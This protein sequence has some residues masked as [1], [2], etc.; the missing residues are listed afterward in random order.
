MKRMAIRVTGTESDPIDLTIK[1]G[2]T[3][4][5]ILA[6]IGLAGYLLSTGVNSSRFFGEDENVYMQ[7]CDCGKL[8]VENSSRTHQAAP[9]RAPVL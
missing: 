8:Y 5:E 9:V 4:R 3:A 7:V 2:T 6:D 1:P